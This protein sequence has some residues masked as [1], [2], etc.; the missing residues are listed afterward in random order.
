M[1]RLTE[2]IRNIFNSLRT[3]SAG[4]TAPHENV[5]TEVEIPDLDKIVEDILKDSKGIKEDSPSNEKSSPI[6]DTKPDRKTKK[7]QDSIKE[8]E[9]KLDDLFDGNVGD[10]Q[11]LS[12]EQF[13]NIRQIATNPFSFMVQ[14]ILA[15]L[16][17]GAGIL[18]VVAIAVEVVKFLILELFKEGRPFDV[19]LRER[20]DDQLIKFLDRKEQEELRASHKSVI[21]T[22]I[23]GLRG[24]SLRGNIGGN[25]FNPDRIPPNFMDPARVSG[26]NFNTRQYRNKSFQ[27]SGQAG[28]RGNRNR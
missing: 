19:R 15:K 28:A 7:N 10:V 17:T 27:I 3:T 16:K 5:V 9:Q 2:E 1:G 18:F 12:K 26:P 6:D 4:G 14:T 22:T 23:G 13:G 8:N 20:V 21:V 24:D 11:K 25:F